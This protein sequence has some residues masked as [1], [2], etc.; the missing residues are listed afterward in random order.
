VCIYVTYIGTK[1]LSGFT[2]FY[3]K[4]NKYTSY[5]CKENLKWH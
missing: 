1:K 2:A 4:R 5:T 3:R